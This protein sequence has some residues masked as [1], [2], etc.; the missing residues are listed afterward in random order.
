MIWITGYL[1]LSALVAAVVLW[2][3]TTPTESCECGQCN[4]Y[5]QMLR[6]KISE[7]SPGNLV[8]FCLLYSV[9]AL[10]VVM[11]SLAQD[12]LWPTSNE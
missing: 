2:I 4:E 1:A 7:L 11:L 3:L 12:F 5:I 6:E 9:I 10:P 8:L